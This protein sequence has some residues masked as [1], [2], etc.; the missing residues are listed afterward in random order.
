M[1]NLKK[2]LKGIY[3]EFYKALYY[4]NFEIIRR[5]KHL[6][7]DFI[8]IK[9]KGLEVVICST[10][11]LQKQENLCFVNHFEFSE[12]KSYYSPDLWSFFDYDKIKK[13]RTKLLEH[14]KR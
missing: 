5:K 1:D 12:K 6:Q 13:L 9:V 8:K 2:G 7:F 4:G 3:T 14:L 11:D 10:D